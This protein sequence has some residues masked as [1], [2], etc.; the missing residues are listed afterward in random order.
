MKNKLLLEVII[1]LS[2]IY[3]SVR[4]TED[5]GT[6]FFTPP[7]VVEPQ[8][9]RVKN[10]LTNEIRS[11]PMEEYLVGVVSGEM[12]AS[13]ELEALKAQ[14]VAARTYAYYNVNR[15][16]SNFDLTND[17]SF[18]VHLTD[19]QMHE[20]WGNDFD[21]YYNKVKQAIKET[22]NEVLTYEGKIIK[23]FYSAMSNGYSESALYA[24]GEDLPYLPSVESLEDKNNQ[25]FEVTTTFTA[26]EFCKYLNLNCSKGI[27]IGN[28]TLTPSGRVNTIDI[29]NYTFKG[30]EVRSYLG[31]RSSDFSIAVNG[32]ITITTKGF[33]HGV[34]MSQY[35]AQ[36]MAQSGKNY[37]E[38][39]AHYY[40]NTTL[41]K[42]D[43]IK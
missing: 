39:L 25:N 30:D 21:L 37:K 9:V 13:F 5:V 2:V 3:V 10:T 27:F 22:E 8:T 1:V 34:G 12:P 36:Y 28:I 23:S 43:S 35:G 7:V 38:I 19:E 31:L 33:G 18:Q 17:T 26:T 29:N 15:K 16:D 20:K 14:A 32:D 24:F 4:S 6:S 42:I 41:E 40:V 11:Y